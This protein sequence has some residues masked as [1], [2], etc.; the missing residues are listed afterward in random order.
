M[1]VETSDKTVVRFLLSLELAEVDRV[2]GA[3]VIWSNVNSTNGTSRREGRALSSHFSEI[4]IA[5]WLLFVDNE[6]LP[7]MFVFNVVRGKEA[8]SV[9]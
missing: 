6:E 8:I 5:T 1:L 3:Y 7:H 4:S 9:P 2:V